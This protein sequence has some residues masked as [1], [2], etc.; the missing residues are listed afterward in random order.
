VPSATITLIG[1]TS[2]F[3][4]YKAVG[5]SPTTQAVVPTLSAEQS[6]SGLAA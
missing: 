6:A 3:F 4:S 5:W 2:K 1:W